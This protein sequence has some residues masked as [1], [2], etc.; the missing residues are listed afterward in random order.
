M[1]KGF[2]FDTPQDTCKEVI[3][4]HFAQY[5]TAEHGFQRMWCPSSR[6]TRVM[7]RFD[8]PD[9]AWAFIKRK[10]AVTVDA[11]KPGV[12]DATLYPQKLKV[13]IEMTVDEEHWQTATL[14]ALKA[15]HL[16]RERCPTVITQVMPAVWGAPAVGTSAPKN[17]RLYVRCSAGHELV[18]AIVDDSE[19]SLPINWKE[20]EL[21]ALGVPAEVLR[22][23]GE[24]LTR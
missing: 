3:E 24:E 9:H 4:A 13:S 6:S 23:I 1:I 19:R 8:S 17:S 16:L 12:A 22:Q 15:C 21:T 7:V 5:L 14:K 2:H 20:A 11:R 18:A 10:L